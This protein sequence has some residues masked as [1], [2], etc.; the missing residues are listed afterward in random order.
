MVSDARRRRQPSVRVVDRFL[1][2]PAYRIASFFRKEIQVVLRQ[3]LLVG[4]L[5]VGP[6]VILLGFGVTFS[7]RQPEMA[8]LLVVPSDPRV[9]EQVTDYSHQYT[10]GFRLVGVTQDRTWAQGELLAGRADVVLVVPPGVVEQLASGRRV[11]LELINRLVDPVQ[12]DWLSYNTYVFFAELNRRVVTDLATAGRSPLKKVDAELS[13]LGPLTA[14]LQANIEAADVTAARKRIQSMMEGMKRAQDALSDIS[15]LLLGAA[16]AVGESTSE[17]SLT[18]LSKLRHNLYEI[19]SELQ[20]I[21]RGLEAGEVSSEM[22]LERLARLNEKAE[23][24]RAVTSQLR[25]IPPEVLVAPFEAEVRSLSSARLSYVGY[26]A[27]GVLALLLQHLGISLASLSLVR[28]RLIGSVELFRV[29]PVSA[30]EI[31]VGKSLAYGTVLL[32]LGAILSAAM[33]LWLGV[34]TLGPLGWLVVALLL[35]AFASVAV[36]FTISAIAH[37]EQQAAQLAMLTLLASVFFSGFFLPL[38]AFHPVATAAAQF[39]PVTH[40]VAALQ[41]LMLHDQPPEPA[42]LVICLALGAAAFGVAI[43]RLH[44]QLRLD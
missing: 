17:T 29:A 7:G 33:P 21:D 34:P 10:P 18:D 39:L 36:G 42:S 11:K 25:A 40:G 1:F 30:L 6:F 22:M 43:W 9:V 26:Y 16:L 2:A 3:R 35:L 20:E 28:E 27:P 38:S 32:I 31:L 14:E 5:V 44:R 37:T 19:E 41:A 13:S 4:S 8:T 12:Q 15:G 24:A 23:R